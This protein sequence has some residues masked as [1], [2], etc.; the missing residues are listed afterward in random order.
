[1]PQEKF[2]VDFHCV[3]HWSKLDQG[4]VG[5]AL[6]E[7]FKLVRPK[8]SAKFVIFEGYDGY[9]TNV[10]MAELKNNSAFIAVKMDGKEIED[11]FG[12]PARV[13]IPHLYAWKSAKFIKAIRFQEKDEPGFWETRGYHNHGDPWKEE[14]YR[15]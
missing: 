2:I 6:A 9:T 11:R 3:T 12:G 13:V 5:V 8:P 14:R 7:I 4:F 10:S 1:L 15:L